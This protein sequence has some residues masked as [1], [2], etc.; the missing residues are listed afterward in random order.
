MK[1]LFYNF[2]ENIIDCFRGRNLL[3]QIAAGVLT[4]LLIVSGFDWY[5]ARLFYSSSIYQYLFLAGLIGFF[6]PVF[7]PIVLLIVGKLWQKG[8]IFTAGLAIGQ[9]EIIAWL[10]SAVYKF[11]TGRAHP[12]FSAAQTDITHIFHFGFGQGGIF[13]GWPSAHTIVAFAMAGAI[14]WLFPRKRWLGLLVFIYAFYI[15]LSVAGSFHW[16]SDFAAGAIMGTIIGKVVGKSYSDKTKV[17][18]EVEM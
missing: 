3:W 2:W 18:V 8:N 16:F 1:S 13:W 10:I 9:A 17:E 5:Y 4:Y 15:G 6:V 11:F 12:T 7:L 14:A